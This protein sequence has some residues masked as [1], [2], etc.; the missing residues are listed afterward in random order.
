LIAHFTAQLAN[1]IPLLTS[2][3][4]SKSLRTNMT[5][6]ICGQLDTFVSDYVFIYIIY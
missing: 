5:A 6:H 2:G 1:H 4:T 3:T